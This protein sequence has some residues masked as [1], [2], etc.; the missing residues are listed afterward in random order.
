MTPGFIDDHTH[1]GQAGAL[2]IGA[3]LL[4]VHTPGPFASRVK[5][6]ALRMSPGAWLTGGDWGA[7]EDW[8]TNSTGASGGAEPRGRFSPDRTIID[9]VSVTTPV[10]LNRWDRSAWLAN[11]VAL[12]CAGLSCDRPVPG[13]ECVNG[14]ATGRV[15]LPH[16]SKQFR[17]EA[18][19]PDRAAVMTM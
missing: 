8:A 4:D 2:L 9:S 11:A 16:S 17:C 5:A 13:L 10:L 15:S 14:N 1:F 6:A 3:N 18:S 7:Y 19:S 12:E